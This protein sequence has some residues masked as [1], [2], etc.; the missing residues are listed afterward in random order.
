MTLAILF[1]L[2]CFFFLLSIPIS[3][4]L[5]MSAIITMLISGTSSLNFFVTNLV[6]AMDSFPL[7]AVPFF[8]L[9][10]E[11]MGKGGITDRLFGLANSI[12]GHLTGG[13]AMATIMTCMFFASISGSSPATV[14]AIGSIMIPAMIRRGY[15]LRFAT[16]TVAAAGSLGVI[17]PPSIDMIMFS[18]AGNTSIG[19]LFLAG[20]L[21]GIFIGCCLMVWAYIYSKRAGYKGSGDKPSIKKI[22]KEI[23]NSK[24]ALT[25]P[26][27]ILGGIYSGIFTPTEAASIS[28]FVGLFIGLFIYRELKISDLP[29]AFLNAGMTTSLVFFILGS[30]TTFGKLLAIEQVPNKMASFLIGLDNPIIIILVMNLILLF[31]GAFMETV[32][33]LIILTPILL[34]IAVA[35][36]FNPVHF[37]IIMIVNLAIG[38][39]TP[40]IG[41][42]LFVGSGISGLSIERLAIGILP[43]FFIMLFSLVV[44]IFWPDL[45]MFLVNL[46]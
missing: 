44:I 30:A 15:D 31:V 33:A 11:L 26:I 39:I 7:M 17:I 28:V 43:Y 1:F 34:P 29:K 9:A 37:G 3:V 20:I 21:P 46:K 45:S 8:M 32:V 38:F 4:A 27:I 35:I 42:N 40:P 22:L 25:I 19:D 6:N 24:W 13:F 41:V 16:V 36:G 2:F 23:N 18:V 14:A 12:V 5:G 10:G